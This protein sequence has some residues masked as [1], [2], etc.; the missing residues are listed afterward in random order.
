MP[1]MRV[2]FEVEQAGCES[3]GKLVTAALSPHGTVESLAIDEQA[4]VASVVLAVTAE[5]SRALIDEALARASTGA[6]HV[7]RVRD[8]SWSVL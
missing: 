1:A 2:A 4:D 5:P 6:G 7:Y 3:C 8:G